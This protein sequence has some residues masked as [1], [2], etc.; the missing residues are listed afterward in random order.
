MA[1]AEEEVGRLVVARLEV[2]VLLVVCWGL[3]DEVV[4]LAGEV[5][6][7]VSGGALLEE[8]D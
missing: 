2:L 1:R 6:D 7:E 5:E 3:A 8:V 4:G